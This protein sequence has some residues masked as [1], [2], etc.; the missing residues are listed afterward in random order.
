[1]TEQTTEPT[2]VGPTIPEL[3]YAQASPRSLGGTSLFE[4]APAS[5]RDAMAV[6]SEQNVIDD[7]AQQLR[8]AGF[9]V[10]QISSTTINIAGPPSLYEQAFECR[11][12]AQERPTRKAQSADDTATYVECPDT[13]VP[14]LIATTGTAFS[15]LLEGVGL[16]E[17]RYYFGVSPLPP[18]DSY[19]RLDVPGG[20]SLAANADL[21]HREASPE[22]A[23]PW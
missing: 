21:A 11:L 8:R 12:A 22:R 14:G 17:P 19:W 5:A 1:M 9:T 16:E 23:S 15:N 4:T 6:T 13:D 2:Q 18:S 3:V 7:A 10:L 20:V